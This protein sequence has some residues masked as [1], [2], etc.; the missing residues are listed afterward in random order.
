MKK[1]ISIFILIAAC[2]S[3]S[4]HAQ[5]EPYYT[6]YRYTQNILNPAAAGSNDLTQFTTNIRSQWSGVNGAPETQSLA[7]DTALGERVGLGL[8]I[9]NDQTFI[10]KQTGIYVDFSYNIQLN[11]AARL[12][13]GLKAGGNSYDVNTGGLNTVGATA[14]PLLA[15]INEFRPNI[16]VGVHLTYDDFF[17]GLS[18]P[19]MLNNERLDDE[20]GIVTTATERPHFYGML[21]Y[22]IGLGPDWQIRPSVLARYVNATPVSVDITTAVMYDNKFEVGAAYRTDAALSGFATIMVQNW[23][24]F[25][26]SYESSFNNPIADASMGTHEVY[27]RFIFNKSSTNNGV[28]S[29]ND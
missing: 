9:V 19:R 25:G 22:N 16:G 21:G 18:V 4:V 27:I 6:L 23:L 15:N 12:Y 28:L 24:H 7:F 1:Y 20:A 10:E 11:D 26:Y 2:T 17:V 8:S 13:F 3:L 29:E 14:D 5:Q